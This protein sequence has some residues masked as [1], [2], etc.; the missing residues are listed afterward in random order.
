MGVKLVVTLFINHLLYADDLCVL[1]PSPTALQMLLN[2]CSEFATSN[3]IVFNVIKTKCM[4]IV[5]KT[6]KKLYVP[7]FYLNNE[8]IHLVKEEKYLGI[9]FDNNLINLLSDERDM[10]RHQRSIYT[11]ADICSS[12]SFAIAPM[13]LNYFYLEAIV[14]IFMVVSFGAIIVPLCL[15]SC[16]LLITMFLENSLVLKGGKA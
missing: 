11:A 5:P 4:Y 14:T 16:R 3:S 15:P 2:L 6:L 8:N 13:T 10:K 1:A 12:L 9:I 7:D